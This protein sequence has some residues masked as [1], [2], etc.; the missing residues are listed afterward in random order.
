M[1][2]ALLSPQSKDEIGNTSIIVHGLS[3]LFQIDPTTISTSTL[4]MLLGDKNELNQL[5]GLKTLDS[6]TS[7]RQ[8]L[9]WYPQLASLRHDTSPLVQKLLQSLFK[10][11]IG[12]TSRR[13][14][15][16]P[17]LPASQSDLIVEILKLYG[18]DPAYILER[19]TDVAA[20]N[21][22]L[23]TISALMV[24]PSPE[25]VRS[26]AANT[27]CSV[28]HHIAL[29]SNNVDPKVVVAITDS[30]WKMEL[31]VHRQLLHVIQSVD[32]YDVNDAFIAA[33]DLSSALVQAAEAYP[34][35]F[36]S[37][38]TGNSAA[39]VAF[40]A[41]VSQLCS[42]D[43]EHVSVTIPAMKMLSQITSITY[44]LALPGASPGDT[45]FGDPAKRIEARMNLLRDLGAVPPAL[46]RQQQQ[47]QLRQIYK[48]YCLPSTAGMAIWTGLAQ[49]A[50][51]LTS[52]I[53]A[54]D[55][56]ST[57][58]YARRRGLATD[59]EG[60]DDGQS[61]LWQN[62]I[63]FLL[64][65][66]TICA[67]DGVAPPPLVDTVGKG[68]LPSIFDD[69]TDAKAMCEQFVRDC[70]DLLASPSIHVRE[71]LKEGLGSE[72]PLYWAK[73]MISQMVK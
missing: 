7:R 28:L 29:E 9:P 63:M 47:R 5:I 6:I 52:K 70:V 44:Q 58:P 11:V 55:V 56:D 10:T 25:F 2:T 50:K 1:Q 59:I 37:T 66:S 19:S 53:I 62:I 45:N 41:I 40:V 33:R 69:P 18:I 27:C 72:L 31:D 35:A 57:A 8:R 3:A 67:Y 24:S 32:L 42:P 14:R 22:A 26:A 4:P 34:E 13:P 48:P 16:S 21:Q 54:A 30:L 60:L 46:G 36:A 38:S 49:V 64:A 61:K 23:N 15:A 51:V 17:E 71:T 73:T 12:D 65:T 68:I 20:Q 39:L 43:F